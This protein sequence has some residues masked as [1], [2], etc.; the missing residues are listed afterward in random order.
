VTR[1]TRPIEDE[2]FPPAAPEPRE[3]ISPTKERIFE[4]AEKLFAQ[5]GFEGTR[6]RDIA[7]QA[8]INISTLHFHWKSKEELYTAV[9]QRQITRRAQL[10]AEIFSLLTQAPSTPQRWSDIV[11][12]V[13]AR[14][15]EFFQRYPHAARLDSYRLLEAT[16][17]DAALQQGQALLFSVA[18]QLRGLL[19]QEL[20]HTV[21]IQL[22]ILSL[23]A[24]LRE[25][26]TGPEVFRHLLGEQDSA[27]IEKRLK[28]HVQQNIARLFQ[29]LDGQER[30]S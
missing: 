17:P 26:F 20:A 15:F 6:T 23:N 27:V 2:S 4:V 28:L 30:K 13:V 7:D 29:L 18:E 9:Y 16:A 3:E 14:M 10:A 21:D 5:K 11:Q 8:G 25:Y 12:G 22:S 24:L 19:P 1:K